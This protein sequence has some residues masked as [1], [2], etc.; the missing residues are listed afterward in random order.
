M[1]FEYKVLHPETQHP[2]GY[3]L[4]LENHGEVHHHGHHGH[5]SYDLGEAG[6]EN[7]GVNRAHNE[8]SSPEYHDINVHE[9]EQ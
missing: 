1:I 6:S 9:E 5:H 8:Y 7:V 3:G 2:K 4:T